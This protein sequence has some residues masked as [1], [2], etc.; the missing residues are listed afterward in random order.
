MTSGERIKYKNHDYRDNH[1]ISVKV[2]KSQ[3][4]G[5]SYRIILNLTDMEYYIRSERTK[6]FIFKSRSYTNL[7]VLKRTARS[8]LE[9]YGVRL[10]MESRN[11]TFGRCQS[12]YTQDQ[13][14]EEQKNN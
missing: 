12:G 4:T 1:K 14:E 3:S 9:Y 10:K 13:W 8:K 2:Y 6:K 5:A 11:R 7:N